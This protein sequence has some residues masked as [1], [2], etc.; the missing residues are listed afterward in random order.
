M[1]LIDKHGVETNL[2]DSL[3]G[4]KIVNTIIYKKITDSFHRITWGEIKDNS[5]N[6]HIWFKEDTEK[7]EL[8]SDG[9]W[10]NKRELREY[11]DSIIDKSEDPYLSTLPL[12]NID[13]G[14]MKSHMA[15]SAKG[16]SLEMIRK[17]GIELKKGKSVLYLST[18]SDPI[19]ILNGIVKSIA[20]DS[21]TKLDN[22]EADY[23]ELEEVK[24][25]VD[26]SLNGKLEIKNNYLLDDNYIKQSMYE[27]ANSEHGLDFVII[28]HLKLDTGLSSLNN[29]SNVEQVFKF[30]DDLAR[31]LSCRVAVST[32]FSR[33]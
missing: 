23:K 11:K 17:A 5:S 22:N 31:K 2:L 32:E 25:A 12:T 6:P 29:S 24:N 7:V 16:H 14:V 27:R 4:K 28:E 30:I 8:N 13:T 19:R 18:E 20:R 10:M 9:V 21:Y 26:L 1:E 33:D 3:P 15:Y